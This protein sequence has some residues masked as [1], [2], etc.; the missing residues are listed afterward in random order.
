M[1][2]K[3]GIYIHIPF[4]VSKCSYCDFYSLKYNENSALEYTKKVLEQIYRWGSELN[5]SA[6][7]LYFGG[8]TPTLL[9]PKQISDIIIASKKG[10]GLK[11]A[12]ITLEANPAE[13]LEEYFVRVAEGGVNRVSFGMQ[14]ANDS[15]LK[16]L[17]RRHN[18]AD[19]KRSVISARNAGIKNISLDIM[20]GI[21]G[22][23]KASL[24][25]TLNF[26]I[27]NNPDH[28]SAYMLSLE[29]NTEL[30]KNK[31]KYDIPGDDLSAEYYLY[32]CEFLEKCGY[33]RYE[34]SNF[35][36]KGLKSRH[37]LKYWLGEDYLGIG[38]AAHSLINGKR[39]YYDRN[40]Q[41]FLNGPKEIYE[42]E[43]GGFEEYVMLRM[44][45]KM[46]VNLSDVKRLFKNANTEKIKKKALTFEKA[47]LIR[48]NGDFISLT[49][50]GA[51][52]SNK[53]I[54]EF[55]F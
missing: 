31:E 13:N 1:S 15:E 53:I 54:A 8:G 7:T 16:M 47:G 2:G 21:P 39:F 22:Q 48:T 19:V 52:V 38:P 27:E 55:L 35:C 17:S 25:N 33:E 41:E 32:T 24:Y 9:S 40:I 6:D 42:G 28:I 34:I 36:K 23:T 4:C 20:L 43:G 46:G 50:K 12:E 14:S 49:D 29:K 10:F 18:S 51:V 30:Y 44:R 11:N 37:N 5:R 26:A 45:L 3:I